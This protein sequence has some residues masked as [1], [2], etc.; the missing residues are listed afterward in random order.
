MQQNRL[1]RAE[2]G[3]IV[4]EEMPECASRSARSEL[5]WLKSTFA[6]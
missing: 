4:S 6:V 1:I 5:R 3:H 2:N